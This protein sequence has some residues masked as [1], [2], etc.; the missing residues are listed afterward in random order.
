MLRDK[1]CQG[2]PLYGRYITR[3]HQQNRIRFFQNATGCFYRITGSALLS[4]DDKANSV[5]NVGPD[6]LFY[7]G[8]LMTHNDEDLPR[9]ECNGRSANVNNQRQTTKFV[10]DL[11]AAGFHSG[12]ETGCEY[13]DVEGFLLF[14]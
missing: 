5:S 14:A 13:E 3:E 1:F 9:V 8:R 10:Q 11:S 7:F 12:T 4:L 2:L 6:S